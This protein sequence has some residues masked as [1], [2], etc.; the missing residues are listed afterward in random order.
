MKNTLAVTLL[1]LSAL[2]LQ[3]CTAAAPVDNAASVSCT[4]NQS[5]SDT[6]SLCNETLMNEQAQGNAQY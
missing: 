3:G 6:G 4:A 2:A 5:D 1:A